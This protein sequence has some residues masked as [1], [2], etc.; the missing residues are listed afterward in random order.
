MR[1]HL[2][3]ILRDQIPVAHPAAPP[4]LDLLHLADHLHLHQHQDHLV[5]NHLVQIA[6]V[7]VKIFRRV[8]AHQIAVAQ[9]VKSRK[10]VKSLIHA[11]FVPSL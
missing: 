11:G 4:P 8:E 5:R 3:Q 1:E 2:A 10:V 9:R 7:A 6:N